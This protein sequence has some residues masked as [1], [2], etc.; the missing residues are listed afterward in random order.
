[1]NIQAHED[2]EAINWKIGAELEKTTPAICFLCQLSM[3]V[4]SYSSASA[5]WE[6][7]SNHLLLHALTSD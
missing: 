4:L 7:N 6:I 3:T 2:I 5:P 1:M